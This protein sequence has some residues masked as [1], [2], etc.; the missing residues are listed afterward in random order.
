MNYSPK[1]TTI[2]ENTET[3]KNERPVELYK[4]AY[5]YATVFDSSDVI[6][7]LDII[8]AYMSGHDEARRENGLLNV[9]GAQP[10]AGFVPAV[11]KETGEQPYM[12]IAYDEA[13]MAYGIRIIGLGENFVVALHDAKD[14]K[15]VTWEEACKLK[16]PTKKQAAL[17][18]AVWDELNAM[19]Q[20][21]GGDRLDDGNWRWTSTEYI[22]LIAWCCSGTPGTLL[23]NFKS[24]SSTVR[25]VLA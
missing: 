3:K 12:S 14:G 9:S 10:V 25:P 22:G 1:L 6:D 23:A 20:E 4:K 7:R 16:A 8:E 15:E 17:M 11:L 21:A 24:H 5:D 19:L 13:D 18:F 2:M